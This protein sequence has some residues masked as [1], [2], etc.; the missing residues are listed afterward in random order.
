MLTG[1][2]VRLTAVRD[3]DT[4][5]ME[6]WFNS[7]VFGRYYDFLPALP[8]QRREVQAMLD[9]MREAADRMIFA[10]RDQKTQGLIGLAG[11]DEI[12]WSNGVATCFL[13]IGEAAYRGRGGGKEALRLLL[14][15]GFYELNFYRVQLNVIAYN[16]AAI[17]LYERHGFV[18]E[19][20]YRRCVFR[21]GKRWD[22]YLYGLLIEE[23]QGL[24]SGEA[25]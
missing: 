2:N 11:F 16:E 7:A 18:R 21:D 25:E 22:M 17:R 13:G 4:A 5:V 9:E 3:D 8:K 24:A 20:T 1:P 15:F 6:E 14:D 19:G 23:W 10:V 12:L